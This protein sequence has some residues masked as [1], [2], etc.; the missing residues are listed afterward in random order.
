MSE[1]EI[2]EEE[3]IPE[4]KEE[5]AKGKDT[6]VEKGKV[7]IDHGYWKTCESCGGTGKD[8]DDPFGFPCTVCLGQKQYFIIP[9]PVEKARQL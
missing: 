2:Q 4:D 5:T 3:E 6:Y 8:P 7:P 1:K 9:A